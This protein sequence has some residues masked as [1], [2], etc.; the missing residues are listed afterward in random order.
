MPSEQKKM[1]AWVLTIFEPDGHPL[2]P[3]FWEWCVP[4]EKISVYEVGKG[5]DNPHY[6]VCLKYPDPVSSQT[7]RN[8]II[9]R[10]PNHEHH[11][12]KFSVWETADAPHDPF[13]DYIAKGLAHGTMPVIKRQTIEYDVKKHHEAYW[14]KNAILKKSDKDELLSD[15]I[16]K[17]MPDK[18]VYSKWSHDEALEEISG[19][20]VD[21]TKG[22]INDHVAWPHIQAVLYRLN[23]YYV[24][25]T[26]YK[27]M[28]AKR[29]H[30]DYQYGK[31]QTTGMYD[32]MIEDQHRFEGP[33][34]PEPLERISHD[35]V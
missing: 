8:R 2:P 16:W 33:P 18:A 17:T 24:K 23:P 12:M 31:E 10:V 15:K 35:Y 1:C 29:G 11:R 6:H 9:K 22:K 26:L 28:L 34:A 20:C 3:A 32:K 21:L 27:R 4:A 5:Q 7:L 30:L 14:A 19:I 13:M 25:K